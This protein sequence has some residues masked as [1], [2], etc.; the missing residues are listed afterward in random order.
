MLVVVVGLLGLGMDQELLSKVLAM[1]LPKSL[2][3]DI[4]KKL[5]KKVFQK[6]LKIKFPK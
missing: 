4:A 2:G 3:N 1:T 5:W 6:A